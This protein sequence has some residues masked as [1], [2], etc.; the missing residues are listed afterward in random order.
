MKLVTAEQM[1]LIDKEAIEVRGIPGPD[2]MENA[3]RGI[4]ERIRDLIIRDP[5]GRKIAIFCGKGNNGGDG[6]V[7]G[8]YLHQY[9]ADVTVYYPAPAEKLSPDAVLNFGRARDVDININGIASAEQLPD[10][11]E[12]D[13][14][15]DAIFGTGFEGVPRGLPA[16]TIEYINA[17][18]IPVI[19]IDC[20]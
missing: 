6:F 8:R 19:A 16:E 10:H 4:A 9:G 11:I 12:A 20:P 7:V 2:L 1:R 15:V 14:I 18:N 3:G 5:H 17:R 13:Y